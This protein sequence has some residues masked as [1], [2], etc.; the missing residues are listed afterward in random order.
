MTWFPLPHYSW[1]LSPRIPKLRAS[2]GRAENVA[3]GIAEP[4]SAHDPDCV[5]SVSW[6]DHTS[7]GS[8]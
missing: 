7:A 3:G 4:K 6:K 1:T 8:R 2:H 5:L